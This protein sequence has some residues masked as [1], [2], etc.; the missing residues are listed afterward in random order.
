M[1]IKIFALITILTLPL[2]S[3]AQTSLIQD[4]SG[5]TSI[6]L[7][8]KSSIFFNASDANA[9]AKLS[10]STIDWFIGGTLKFKS[11]EGI[12]NLL[13][14]Y[15][16]KP[17][18]S[19]TLFGGH[20]IKSSGKSQVQYIY[21]SIKITNSYFNILKSDNSNTFDD[22]NFLG[23][24]V[25]I[26]Y[27]RFDVL[28]LPISKSVYLFG[29]TLNYSYTNNLKELKSVQA[30]NTNTVTSG[31]SQV[32]LM[33]DKKSGFSG[34]YLTFGELNL[35]VDFYI[36]PKIVWKQIA[37]GGYLRSQL[38]GLNPKNNAGVGLIVG[39]NDAPTNI[40]FGIMYQ[41]NDIFNQLNKESDFIK[42]G[43]INLVT[44][45]NF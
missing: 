15:K 4:K 10:Y 35:N 36:Y 27:N 45:Y 42:R 14:G 1:I 24:S 26:G 21:Y 2:L 22:K 38:A 33:M 31:S 30:Y 13:E 7:N 17:E 9:S 40:V 25:S 41:F 5:E 6:L 43:G 37:I 8:D 18:V 28:G 3:I 20:P 39:Q 34:D 32:I 23:G 44:G 29:I 11:T 19:F 16:L 12:S